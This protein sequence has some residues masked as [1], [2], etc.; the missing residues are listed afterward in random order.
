MPSRGWAT[1]EQTKF[2]IEE[3]ARW[4]IAKHGEMTLKSFYIRTANTFHSKWPET[5][6]EDTLQEAEGDAEKAEQ[7]VVERCRK[8]CFAMF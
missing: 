7:L 5:P 4:A 3:D 8:V 2:L 1:P 6:D